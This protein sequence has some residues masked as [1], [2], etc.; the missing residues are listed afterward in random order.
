MACK[1]SRPVSQQYLA[2]NAASA[3]HRLLRTGQVRVNGKRVQGNYRVQLHDRVRLPPVNLSPFPQQGSTIPTLPDRIL[4]LVR[5]RII[6]QDEH[7][8]VLN[9]P[10]G[11]AVHSGSSHAWGLI[12]AVRM[13]YQAQD[14]EKVPEL[15]HRLDLD[16]SGCLVFGLTPL[17]TRKWVELLRTGKIHKQYRALVRG[18]P[19]QPS[20]TISVPLIKGVVRSG[21]RM[22]AVDQG[23]DSAVTHFKIIQRFDLATTFSAALLELKLIT[24]RTHQIRA[25]LQWAGF[26]VAGDTK[27]GDDLFNRQMVRYG[28]HRMFLHA[29]TLAFPHPITGKPL[30]FTAPLDPPLILVINALSG[31]HPA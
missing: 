7:L 19:S 31:I 24:G 3:I 26:P 16:T 22:V 9:K 29:Q 4:Q 2:R 27:Y 25:H 21:E 18:I 14:G 5:E 23:G 10:H 6:W 20:G 13:I 28:L 15:C 30:T 12:D 1:P 11:M 17:A 8:L